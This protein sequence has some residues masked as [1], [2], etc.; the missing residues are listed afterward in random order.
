MTAHLILT[1]DYE[2]FGNGSG[3]LEACVLQPSGQIMNIVEPFKAPVTFFVEALEFMALSRELND[4][5]APQQLKQALQQ[6]H[7]MQL[8]IHPQ[9]IN[10]VYDSSNNWQVDNTRWRIGDLG[11][12]EAY[13]VLQQAKSWLETEIAENTSNYRC[14]A[15]RAGG[16]C[17][18]PSSHIIQSLLELGF[19]LDSSVA[20]GQWRAGKGEWSDFRRAPDLPIWKVRQDVLNVATDG[21]YEVPIACGNIGLW[22][23]ARSLLSR[24]F[25]PAGST[26]PGCNGSYLGPHKGLYNHWRAKAI[27]MMQIGNVMLD[28]SN[29][30]EA[31][32]IDITRQWIRRYKHTLQPIPVVAIAHTKNFTPESARALKAYLDWANGQDIVFSTY[33][34]WLEVL[35]EF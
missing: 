30:R 23:H 14:L 22:Q 33:G 2:L 5:R 28:F 27:R 8:H 24:Q 32:L 12:N 29:M 7:D 11:G 17:I 25:K 35:D 3:C 19:A 20:P 26:A 21:L 10:P 4:N 6:G 34:K 31:E 15:F 16:W 13:D 1:V 9:W 18:Q